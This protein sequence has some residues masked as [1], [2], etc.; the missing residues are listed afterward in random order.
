MEITKGVHLLESTKGSFVYLVLDANEPLLIDTG[1]PGRHLKI[2]RELNELGVKLTDIAH[3][4]LT[5]SDVDHIGNAKSLKS[6]SSAKLW[7]PK[8]D[9][10]YIHRT[11][12]PKGLRRLIS[13]TIK[14]DIPEIDAFYEPGQRIGQVEM[15]PT[16]GHTPGHVSFRYG[17]VLFTGD[18][19]MSSRGKLK[20]SPGFLTEDKARLRQ[21]IHEVGRLDFNYV[22]PAH[23]SP[24]R[25]GNLW[26]ALM[27]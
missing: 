10:P 15:I 16:P 22:C 8:D 26:D 11:Q 1:N 23:G 13:A 24:V 7:A 18:L 27:T 5:H 25:R 3:L 14:A 6:A 4:L 2:E 17:D 19:V 21:S 20:P 9:L 12:K